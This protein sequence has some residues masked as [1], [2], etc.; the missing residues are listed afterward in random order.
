MYEG[1]LNIAELAVS[2]PLATWNL[3]DFRLVETTPATTICA[4]PW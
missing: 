3:L 1:G 4:Q 2:L